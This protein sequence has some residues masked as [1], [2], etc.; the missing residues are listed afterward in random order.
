[1]NKVAAPCCGSCEHYK[2]NSRFP[3]AKY[4]NYVRIGELCCYGEHYSPCNPIPITDLPGMS[5]IAHAYKAIVEAYKTD[6]PAP[7]WA[8]KAVDTLSIAIAG[9]G[10]AFEKQR[11]HRK[12]ALKELKEKQALWRNYCGEVSE[13]MNEVKRLKAVLAIGHFVIRE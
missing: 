7:E 1:M 13:Q 12:W 11:R 2:N 6:R 3:C 10:G 8:I 5:E 9:V 4:H